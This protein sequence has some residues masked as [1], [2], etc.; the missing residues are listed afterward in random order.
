MRLISTPEIMKIFIKTNDSD[1]TDY[2]DII[3]TSEI[4]S[5]TDL[6]LRV[7]IVISVVI[8]LSKALQIFLLKAFKVKYN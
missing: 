7:F 1:N 6:S 2:I 8:V 5:R 4:N 3:N